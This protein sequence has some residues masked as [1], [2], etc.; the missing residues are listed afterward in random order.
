MPGGSG[1]Y[2]DE[3]DESDEGYAIPTAGWGCQPATA[4]EMFDL[5]SSDANRYEVEDSDDADA[6][7]DEE[8]DAS[9]AYDGSTQNLE[10]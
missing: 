8:E 7:A 4:L 10:H 2:K 5:G 3:S 6:D 1:N 9:Q